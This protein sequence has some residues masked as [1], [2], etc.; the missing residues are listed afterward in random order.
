MNTRICA[1]PGCGRTC[2]EGKRFCYIHKEMELR[3]RRIFTF[4]GRSSAWHHLYESARWRRMSREFLA[5]YP[6]C[7]V[8]GGRATVA[9]HITPHRGNTALFYD[10]GNLQPMCQRCHS[11]KTLAENGNFNSGRKRDE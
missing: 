5:R 2:Q 4:R 1:K 9:D 7:F 3:P 10:E 6:V 11:R 8:C